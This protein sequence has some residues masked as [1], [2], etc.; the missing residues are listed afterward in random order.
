MSFVRL[1]LASSNHKDLHSDNL[2]DD[3]QPRTFMKID[4]V[5]VYDDNLTIVVY[6]KK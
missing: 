3:G 5:K 1:P 4:L 2:L 6:L